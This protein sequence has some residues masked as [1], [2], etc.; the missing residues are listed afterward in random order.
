MGNLIFATASISKRDLI[1]EN[2]KDL[3]CY[4]GQKAFIEK[5]GE[6][7]ILY[8]PLLGLDLP[9]G[10]IKEGELDL[11]ASLKR[12]VKE[13]TGLTINVIKP[14]YTWF[15]TVPIASSHRGAGKKIFHVGYKCT[16]VSGKI[17]LSEEHDRY[18]WIN[19]SSYKKYLNAGFNEA[20]EA[21]FD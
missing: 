1:K 20:L 8:D 12:E 15:F 7:L 6:L 13:E 21:H 9:G 4:I 11:Y 17:Q 10:K 18:E 19:K 2:M 5:N 3:V 14:F 16:Y